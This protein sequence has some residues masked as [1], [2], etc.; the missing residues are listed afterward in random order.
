[1]VPRWEWRSFGSDFPSVQ[2]TIEDLSHDRR[3]SSEI[4]LLSAASDANVKIRDGLLDVKRLLE[5]DGELERWSPVLKAPF[6]IG[7]DQI[8]AV[9]RHW[10]I[11][12]PAPARAR[13]TVDQFLAEIVSSSS[14]LHTIAVEKDRRLATIEGCTVEA[15]TLAIL[16]TSVRTVAVESVDAAAVRRVVRALGLA[17]APPV[18]YVSALKRLV[19]LHPAAASAGVQEGAS[20]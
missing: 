8:A 7:A 17:D 1:V 13:Y 14:A 12:V 16:G 20:S 10:A 11:A 2:A 19:G 4:Y 15:A 3:R 18:N 5:I 9:A 6:P